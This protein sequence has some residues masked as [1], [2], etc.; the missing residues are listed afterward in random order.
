MIRHCPEL[1]VPRYLRTKGPV[2]LVP[3]RCKRK[4]RPGRVFCPSHDKT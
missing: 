1:I 3:H 2:R 4:P